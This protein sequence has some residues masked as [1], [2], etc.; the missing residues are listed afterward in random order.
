MLL[1]R[2]LAVPCEDGGPARWAVDHLFVDQDAIPTIVEVKRQENTELRRQV[3]GQVLEYAANASSYWRVEELRK[4]FEETNGDAENTL[5]ERLGYAGDADEFWQALKTNLQAGRVR[6]LIVAD[7]IPPE[8]RLIVEFLNQQMDPAEVLALEL[9]QFEGAGMKTIVPLV[10]GQTQEAQNKKRPGA[11]AREWTEEEVFSRIRQNLGDDF[12]KVATEIVSWFKAEGAEIST[13]KG[14]TYGSI[15]AGVN[16]AGNKFNAFIL[17]DGGNIEVAFD[18]MMR[19]SSA[20]KDMGKREEL[21]AKLNEIE[22]LK[23]SASV[24]DK[25]PSVPLK[26][27][28]SGVNRERFFDAARWFLKEIAVVHE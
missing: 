17:W 2:E 12:Y 26:L 1:G 23:L 11:P 4:K 25:F 28:L 14:A 9:R 10:Y 19:H 16:A 18:R 6:L 13:G 24:I 20:F 21:R 15:R 5:S 22:G 3:I 8:L 7:Y 27:L